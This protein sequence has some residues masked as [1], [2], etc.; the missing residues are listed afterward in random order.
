M[1]RSKI[2]FILFVLLI[3]GCAWR[4]ILPESEWEQSR[5][6]SLGKKQSYEFNLNETN[7]FGELLIR[8]IPPSQQ[9]LVE[10]YEIKIDDGRKIGVQDR[11]QINRY[12][13]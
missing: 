4:Y 9:W 11:F 12:H 3:N 1:Y 10:N 13:I 7:K 8:C 2:A 6:E 5:L